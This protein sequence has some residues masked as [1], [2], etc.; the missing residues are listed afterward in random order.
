MAINY[1][2]ELNF[3]EAVRDSY[4]AFARKE[5]SPSAIE[6][7]RTLYCHRYLDASPSDRDLFLS[8]TAPDFH[9]LVVALGIYL[10]AKEGKDGEKRVVMSALPPLSGQLPDLTSTTELY[11]KLQSVYHTQAEEDLVKFNRIL[12]ELI[13]LHC[14]EES[15]KKKISEDIVTTFCKNCY[16][17]MF[18]STRSIEEELK[19]CPAFDLVSEVV[20]DEIFEADPQQT[21]LFWYLALRAADRFYSRFARWPGDFDSSKT[22]VLES[23]QEEVF[24]EMRNLCDEFKISHVISE[25]CDSKM[26]VTDEPALL[27]SAHSIEITRYGGC[28]IHN[29]S[30][31]IGGIAAQEAVKIVTRQYVPINNTYV[32]NGIVS[33]GA[34]YEL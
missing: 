28:E 17:I 30:S 12:S 7:L 8:D 34:T 18:I 13:S 33:C 10:G 29:I 4:K 11:V 20:T 9:F 6:A 3:Q 14:S 26:E 25:S 31:L 22:N 5:F 27:S 2:D 21:P 32:F 16:G 24:I 19:T 15:G 23:D 1:K